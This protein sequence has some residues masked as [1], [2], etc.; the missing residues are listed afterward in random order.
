LRHPSVERG[1]A[2]TASAE[3]KSP[4]VEGVESL[5]DLLAVVSCGDETA[6]AR[7]YDDV[8]GS[9]YGIALRVVK[10]AAVAEEVAQE[11][12]LHIW[13]TAARFDRDQGS[14]I[15]YILTI[16][17]RHAVDVHRQAKEPRQAVPP[18]T[19]YATGASAVDTR[20]PGPS[21][22]QSL[23]ALTP[24]QREAVELAYFDGYTSSDI[25]ALL[26]VD[27]S[28]VKTRLRDGLASIAG[29]RAGMVGKATTVP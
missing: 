14:A 5:E 3:A 26:S 28:T 12:L 19:P 7:L 29:I 15:T 4:A 11:A 2:A 1:N 22:R 21:E 17:H 16:V 9:V 8:S 20:C 25:A 6:F 10:N 23:S 13:R 18:E 27:S 24:V